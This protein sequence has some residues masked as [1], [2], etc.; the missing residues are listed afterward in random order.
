LV[1]LAEDDES[2][3]RAA[4]A[5]N[6]TTPPDL[7]AQ[8]SMDR[9]V[10]VLI[11]AANN[12]HTPESALL[13]LVKSKNVNVRCAVAI[14]AHRN[15]KIFSALS[16]DSNV[17]VRRA[18]SNNFA[19]ETQVLDEFALFVET[20]TDWVNLL[21]HPNL[22]KQGVQFIADQLFNTS[23]ADSPWF[24][25]EVST[26][27]LDLEEAAL[28]S[29]VL[30]YFGRNP[31]KSVLAKRP[32]APVMALCA[33]Q[34]VDPSRIVKVVGSTDWLV[35]A[36]VARNPG[37]PSNLLKKLSADAHPLVAAL[38]KSNMSSKTEVGK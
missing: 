15:E 27:P 31:N 23:A 5:A 12:P 7:L 9:T 26:V 13:P 4:V 1:E 11:A 32:L 21:S 35:R 38:A 28:F 19:L 36:A 29:S 22:S 30:N 18:L 24:K 33:V 20:E 37:T 6:S 25:N 34:A 2:T 16:N 8:L 17:E 10:D 14:Q 3:V